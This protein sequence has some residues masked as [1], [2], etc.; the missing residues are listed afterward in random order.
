MNGGTV[1]A[2]TLLERV[3]ICIGHTGLQCTVNYKGKLPVHSY[4]TANLLA[5][6]AMQR[7]TDK[8]S[9]AE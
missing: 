6:I 2:V 3:N 4:A 7:K 8:L 1:V 9:Q 5:A